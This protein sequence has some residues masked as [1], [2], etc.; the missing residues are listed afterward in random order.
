MLSPRLGRAMRYFAKDRGDSSGS[1]MPKLTRKKKRDRSPSPALASAFELHRQR[2]LDEAEGGYREVLKDDP[3]NWQSLHQLGEIHLAR[4]QY[5]E[6]LQ[7]LGAAMKANPASPEAASNYGFVLRHLKRDGEAIAYFDRALILRPGY[8]PALL[9]RGASL[10]RLGRREE[11]LKSLDRAI[12]LDPKNF[13]AHYNRANV[14]HELKRFDEALRSF[15]Q[16]L[17]LEPEDADANFN[18]G[19]T[20]LL[21]GDFSAGWKKYEW[22][23]KAKQRAE[24]RNF[25][26]ALW[27]G[28]EPVAGKTIL[29]HAE[30]GFG[31]TIQFVRYVPLLARMGANIVLEVQPP[32]KPFL[33]SVEGAVTVA[34]GEALP[35]FDLHCPILSL[36]LAF[37]TELASIPASTPYL[38]APNDRIEKWKRRLPRQRKLI[39]AIAWSG[40]VTHELDHVRSI[41]IEKLEPLFAMPDI[42]WISI[43][44]DL[45]PGDAE[46]LAA[47]PGI[48]HVGAEL[49]DFADTAAVLSQADLAISVDTSTVHLAGALGRPV[50]ALLQHMPD[51][52]WLLDREDSTWYPSARLFRQPHFGD[53]KSVIERASRELANFK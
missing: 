8:V 4:G 47:H 14:L 34:R 18:E 36:P 2:R 17:A 52:R 51:F 33:A 39:V 11:A 42:Q 41:A 32:L 53:W 48:A 46:F 15:A 12:E 26:P 10:H 9:T 25:S 13:K 49:A 21:I 31:D 20:R 40:S 37:K 6:A 7:L 30:Q 27:L 3:A 38:A 23:W 35:S 45:R 29:V 50:W 43:Q 22:R 16:A 19:M 1:P 28:G 5:V 44:R 24:A